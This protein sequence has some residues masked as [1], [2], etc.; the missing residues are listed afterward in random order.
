MSTPDQRRLVFP[1]PPL[2]LGAFLGNL[3]V[4]AGTITV[5]PPLVRGARERSARHTPAR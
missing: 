2:N 5:L 4:G 1:A 3:V